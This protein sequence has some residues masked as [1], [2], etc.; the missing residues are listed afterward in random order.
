LKLRYQERKLS[1]I[2]STIRLVDDMWRD[3][4]ESLVDE[5]YDHVRELLSEIKIVID[6]L[7]KS[8][9]NEI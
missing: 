5:E 4:Y 1:Y 2:N 7:N 3:I 8:I 9:S 6:D